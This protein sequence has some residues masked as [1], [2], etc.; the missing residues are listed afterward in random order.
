MEAERSQGLQLANWQPKRAGSVVS[1]WV[2]KP[3][4]QES[5]LVQVLVWG[6]KIDVPAQ[7]VRQVR[8]PFTQFFVCSSLQLIRWGP[9]TLERTVCF[10]QSTNS[11]VN[12]TQKYSHSHTQNNIWPN[13][14]VP[15]S[16]VSMTYKINYHT[17]FLLEWLKYY[18]FVLEIQ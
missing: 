17:C 7:S 3:E 14:W 18:F 5:Q 10:T 16:P 4:N 13:V 9:A 11:N 2:Q 8:F 1:V 12:L 6:W 15:C